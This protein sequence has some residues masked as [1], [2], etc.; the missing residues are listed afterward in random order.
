MVNLAVNHFLGK[1]GCTKMNCAQAVLCGFKEVLNI[2]D[3]LI[4]SYGNFGTGH[5]PNNVCGAIFAAET[6]LEMEQRTAAIEALKAYFTA[7]AGSVKCR[8]IRAA[9]AMSCRG[10]VD[11]A[12]RV[13]LE[14]IFGEAE[15]MTST[16]AL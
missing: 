2:S 14:T 16:I 11:N 10:C 9:K 4:E 13:V 12:A 3:E 7:H 6:I 5:A 15:Q 8:E 1:N